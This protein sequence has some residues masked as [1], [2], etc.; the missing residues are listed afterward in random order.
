MKNVILIFLVFT[1]INTQAGRNDPYQNNGDYNV[2]LDDFK[3]AIDPQNQ[4]NLTD[5]QAF[6]IAIT[7]FVVYVIVGG[8]ILALS[9]FLLVRCYQRRDKSIR[10]KEQMSRKKYQ[11]ASSLGLNLYQL[12]NDR[13]L[14]YTIHI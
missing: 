3:Y 1:L 12:N 6:S 8:V 14:N 11:Y 4:Y 7:I 10:I 9:V 5:D 13:R 2:G